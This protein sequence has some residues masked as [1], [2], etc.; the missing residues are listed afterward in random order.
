MSETIK[1]FIGILIG[2]MIWE[3]LISYDDKSPYILSVL[4]ITVICMFIFDLKIPKEIKQ[5]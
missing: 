4:S 2:I 3:M 5:K 1:F